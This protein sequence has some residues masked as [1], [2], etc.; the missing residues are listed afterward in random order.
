LILLL[1]VV[2]AGAYVMTRSITRELAVARLQSDFVA[3]VSHEFRTPL[4]SL[5]QFIELLDEREEPPAAKR[6][7]FYR[8]QS[9]AAG[10]LTQ[11]VESLLDF[12]RMEAGA[13]PFRMETLALAPLVGEV[14]R[15][16]Q[17]DGGTDDF[18]FDLEV[19]SGEDLVWADREALSR[20]LRNLLENAVKY[21]GQARRVT[22]GVRRQHDTVAISV[23]DEGL[24][25]PRHEQED[26][27]KKFVRGAASRTHGITGTGIGLAMVRY[28]A[29]AH[30]GRV[31]VE[32]VVGQGSTFT[33]FLPATLPA[34][35]PAVSTAERQDVG[36]RESWHAS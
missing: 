13:H 29:D 20:A 1:V 2:V 21:S 7:A 23:R 36:S 19:G 31:T 34:G 4:T 6:R 15:E 3:A 30:G 24:G 28:I 33:I 11:L 9:R 8:A 32:S 16:F 22:V 27:F 18:I 5:H 14:I 17:R 35:A 25:V 12:G 10:R 26:I